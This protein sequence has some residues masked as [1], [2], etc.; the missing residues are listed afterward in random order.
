[1]Q[2]ESLGLKAPVMASPF[3]L[4]EEEDEEEVV[5][6]PSGFNSPP[7]KKE[8]EEDGKNEIPEV[9]RGKE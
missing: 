4:G 8:A 1:M 3:V 2:K 6:D 7:T 9:E 5:G